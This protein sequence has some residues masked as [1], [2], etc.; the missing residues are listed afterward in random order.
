MLVVNVTKFRAHLKDYLKSLEKG[1]EITIIQNSLPI[2]RLVPSDEVQALLEERRLASPGNA[3][4]MDSQEIM[5][6]RFSPYEDPWRLQALCN[7]VIT[8]DSYDKLG[9]EL[10]VGELEGE[11]VAVGGFRMCM[12]GTADVPEAEAGPVCVGPALKNRGVKEHLLALLERRAKSCG[13]EKL[14]KFGI[15]S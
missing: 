6:R 9:G 3:F 7:Q 15:N 10:W 2:G 5:F 4:K 14:S 8:V 1:E 12:R 11:V 13:Y